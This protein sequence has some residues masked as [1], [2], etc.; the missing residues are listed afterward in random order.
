M[1]SVAWTSGDRLKSDD[2]SSLMDA[3]PLSSSDERDILMDVSSM[4][5]DGIYVRAFLF[6]LCR[7]RVRIVWTDAD[8]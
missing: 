7:C 3:P 5:S 1:D 6:I 4:P 2:V 8:G